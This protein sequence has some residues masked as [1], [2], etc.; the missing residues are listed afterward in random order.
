MIKKVYKN[1]NRIIVCKV[2][3]GDY[4]EGINFRNAINNLGELQINNQF[5]QN[6]T[7]YLLDYLNCS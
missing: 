3:K 4:E 5:A 2:F 7:V 1:G 6:F